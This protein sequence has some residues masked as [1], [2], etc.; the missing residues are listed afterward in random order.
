[1]TDPQFKAAE[2]LCIQTA[3]DNNIDRKTAR[4]CDSYSVSCPNCPFALD[5]ET[6]EPAM[7]TTQ[8]PYHS[9]IPMKK[10]PAEPPREL[11]SVSTDPDDYEVFRTHNRIKLDPELLKKFDNSGRSNDS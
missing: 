5:K 11:P 2:A 3:A 9:I 10:Q 6:P 8:A 7:P 4:N 1:M